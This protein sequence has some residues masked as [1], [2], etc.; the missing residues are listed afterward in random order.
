MKAVLALLVAASFS[1]PAI[2]PAAWTREAGGTALKDKQGRVIGLDL[3]STWVTDADLPAIGEIP[4]LQSLD[5]SMTRITDHGVRSLKNATGLQV[6]KL[7]YAELVTDEGM[8]V[9]RSFKQLKEIDLRGTKIT[10]T[11]LEFLEGLPTLESVDVGYAQVTDNGIDHFGNLTN[12]KRLTI[13][14]NKLTDVGLQ[15]LRQI[16]SLLYLDLGGSQRTDSGLWSV[17]ITDSG[18]E[19]VATLEK[20][21][22]LRLDGTTITARNLEPLKR[23]PHLKRLSLAGCKRLANDAAPMLEQFQGLEILDLAGSGLDQAAITALRFKLPKTKVL[24]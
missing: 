2:D 4:K 11:T 3:R 9:V 14:G 1:L 12:L 15:A 19:A 6:L 17:S 20:L 8:A 24:G 23:L 5:L 18:I 22:E 16:P 10:D 7:R 13:S 21:E